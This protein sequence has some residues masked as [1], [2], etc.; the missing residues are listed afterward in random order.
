MKK[1]LFTLVM[2]CVSITVN[3]Q[4]W[5]TEHI[6][7]D[8]LLGTKS[9]TGYTYQD[10][11]KIKTLI[12]FDDKE[13]DFYIWSETGVFDFNGEGA[14]GGKL[15]RGL[16]GIYDENGKLIKKYDKYCFEAVGTFYNK[17]HSN[18]YSNMGGNNRK[19]AK[20]IIEH[21]KKKKGSVRFFIPVYN[22]LPFD[23]TVPC[24]NN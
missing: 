12:L 21:L 7:G 18:R 13:E 17:V 16:V 15:V 9:C 22:G 8:E 20:N 23:F 4:A 11:E 5:V 3:A 2:L 1:I 19:N 10:E 6:E 14:S 24:M